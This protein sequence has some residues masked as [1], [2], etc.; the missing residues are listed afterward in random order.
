MNKLNKALLYTL[1]GCLFTFTACNKEEVAPTLESNFEE[2]SFPA[3]ADA[4]IGQDKTGVKSGEGSGTVQYSYT[5]NSG[6]ASYK[7]NYFDDATYGNWWTG[8]AYSKKT[9]TTLEGTEGSLV[10]IP[11]VGAN[12]SEV[13][14]VMN[15]SETIYFDGT[16][17]IPQS[18][19]LT[20]NAYVYYSLLKGDQFAKK[21]GGVDGTD[22]DF[23]KVII[24][25]L[26]SQGKATGKVEF[27]LAD[28]RFEESSEDYIV[29]TW[30]T[31][32]LSSLGEVEKLAFSYESSDT[33]DWGINTPLYVAID[34]L[35]FKMP[36]LEE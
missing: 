20:N 5:Y 15:G 10:A 18:I 22:P 23:F 3:G 2:L 11:G 1:T 31:V 32:D 12:S 19:Q 7:L 36:S 26:D 14:A 35:R 30:E 24:T 34:D 25:G 28:Y 8:V 9:D 13:Y 17:V 33:G 16:E 21:F 27:Y 6:E 4:Y 29:D